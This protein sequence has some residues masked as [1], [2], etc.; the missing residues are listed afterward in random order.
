MAES[1][2]PASVSGTL[3]T[4]VGMF[5]RGNGHLK[6]PQLSVPSEAREALRTVPRFSE[7][8][9]LQILIGSENVSS[10]LCVTKGNKGVF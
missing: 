3:K 5:Y 9:R 7:E 2:L 8:S 6:K 10:W 4:S 1:G